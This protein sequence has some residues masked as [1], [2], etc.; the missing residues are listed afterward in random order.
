MVSLRFGMCY[1]I[2]IAIVLKYALKCLFQI[3]YIYV[4][5]HEIFGI[6][7][8]YWQQNAISQSCD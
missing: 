1:L 6:S 8:S 3:Q 5:S 2:V 4:L 7:T